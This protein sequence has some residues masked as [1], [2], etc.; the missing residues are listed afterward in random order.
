M[1]RT[2]ESACVPFHSTLRAYCSLK[3]HWFCNHLRIY[4][5]VVCLA[6]DSLSCFL[7]WLYSYQPRSY[8][9]SQRWRLQCSHIYLK[10]YFRAADLSRH[11]TPWYLNRQRSP[12]TCSIAAG[13]GEQRNSQLLWC[14]VT[15]Y[16]QTLLWEQCEETYDLYP[17]KIVC[18]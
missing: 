18:F 12:W 14:L 7:P 8:Y 3:S 10:W 17:Q 16:S 11:T 15:A 4:P 2:T 5:S 6:Q 9:P 13:W 1:R